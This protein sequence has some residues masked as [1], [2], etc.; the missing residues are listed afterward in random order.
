MD[1]L[2]KV[3]CMKCEFIKFRPSLLPL[4]DTPR[5]GNSLSG[6][7]P[8]LGKNPNSLRGWGWG[9]NSFPKRGWGWGSTFLRP[10]PRFPAQGKIPVPIPY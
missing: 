7:R 2:R 8:A 6:P 1:L 9:L 4:P 3:K 10:R 5:D